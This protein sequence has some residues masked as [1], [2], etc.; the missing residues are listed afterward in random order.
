VLAGFSFIVSD[1]SR[2]VGTALSGTK[3]F[4]GQITVVFLIVLIFIWSGTQWTAWRLGFQP[5]LGPAWFDLYGI[6]VYYPPALFW[7]WYFCDAYAPRIFME[8][9]IIAASGGF[10]AIAIAILMSVWRAREAEDVE[11]YGAARWAKPDE[12][13]EAGLLSSDGVVLGKL[14]EDYLRHNGPEHVLCFAP[15]HSGKGVILVWTCPGSFPV[16]FS[17]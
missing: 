8:G 13:R 10:L 11:T 16:R 14:G 3:I 12:V 9:G 6:P 5:Q 2:E 4:W 15:T 17:C 7:W 1:I